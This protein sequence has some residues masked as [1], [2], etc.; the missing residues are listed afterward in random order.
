MDIVNIFPEYLIYEL[1]E[2]DST[3]KYVERQ[4]G[5]TS[6]TEGSVIFTNNQTAGVGQAEN[7]WE[8]E[9]HKN[10][11]ATV[12]LNPSFLNPSD[13][14]Y[15][16]I[17]VSL[18]TCETVCFFLKNNYTQIKWPNDIYYEHRKIAG[19]LIKNFIMGNNV[20]ICIAGLGLNVNQ[21]KFNIAPIATSLK[22]LSGLEYD[23]PS[24]LTKWHTLLAL[25][26]QKL[27]YDK[28]ALRQLYLTKLYLKD[29]FVEFRINGKQ[30]TATIT[31]IDQHGQ[32]ELADISGKIYIC[33][34]RE[35]VFPL[36]G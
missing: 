6:F 26:Y 19:I 23:I 31:G 12:V 33:G 7:M 16:T 27:K 3:N 35:I 17:V 24:V 29:Q 20:S 4:L 15:L 30:V 10:L 25:Y 21:T 8:S 28:D 18:A 36:L 13:Q 1:P 5:L 22:L 32:L 2:V 34:L 14:F 9:P 11:I